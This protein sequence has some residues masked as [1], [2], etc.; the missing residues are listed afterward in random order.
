MP[1]I[2]KRYRNRK[3]YN[4][5]SKRYVTL[6][7]I[8]ELI[9]QHE[10]I[11]VIDNDSEND[12]TATTLSQIIFGLEKNLTGVLPINLLISLVQ[13]GGKR[14]DEVRQNIF[15]SMNL[16]RHFDLEIERRV[17]ILITSGELSQEAGT[18]LLQKLLTVG[19][20][21]EDVIEN[22]EGKFIE[23]LRE[24]QIPTKVD[25]QTLSKR[26]DTLSTKIEGF[27]FDTEKEV[28]GTEGQIIE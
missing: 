1:V 8:E 9:K 19:S 2:I 13:S 5:Q 21:Q 20:K 25:F 26:I 24:Q 14:M 22:I 3:L 10:E 16:V 27:T 12:I 7:E 6:E 18:Q 11:K 17:N 23:L 28:I 15:N 4:T